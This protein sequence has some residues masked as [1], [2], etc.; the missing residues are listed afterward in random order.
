MVCAV[1][2]SKTLLSKIKD[3]ANEYKTLFF[4]EALFST[5]CKANN[6]KYDTPS[7]LWSISYRNNHLESDI[8]I[9]NLYHPVK[10]M[11]KHTIFRNMLS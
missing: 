5:I 4:L 8:N 7:E 10:D 6:L 9:C 1:R 3:Y 11:N 2:M